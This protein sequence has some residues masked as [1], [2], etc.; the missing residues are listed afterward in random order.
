VLTAVLETVQAI[1]DH[2]DACSDAVLALP[3]NRDEP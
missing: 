1:K 3:A 2:A